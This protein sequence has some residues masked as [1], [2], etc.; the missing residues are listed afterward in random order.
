MSLHI[1]ILEPGFKRSM[2]PAFFQAVPEM[3]PH[4]NS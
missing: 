2:S 1:D 4:Y 3:L